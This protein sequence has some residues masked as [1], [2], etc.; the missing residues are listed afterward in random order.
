MG[1]T[2]DIFPGQTDHMIET[3][4]KE[5]EQALENARYW[6]V[7]ATTDDLT[8]LH[9]RRMLG[10]IPRHISQRRAPHTKDDIT[11]LFIDLDDFGK[12]NK[13]FGDDVGDQ[14]LR[15]L[16]QMIRKNIRETDIAIRKGGDE[17]V[18]FL[19][20]T[21][22]ELAT[23]AVVKRLELMLDGE[24]A[25]T[26]NDNIIPIRGSIGVFAYD[27]DLSPL[28]NLRHADALMR[29]AKKARKEERMNAPFI[30]SGD[31]SAY[32]SSIS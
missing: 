30:M 28:D 32:A 11:L 24:L 16:G 29:E 7:M 5:L 26:V 10:E 27:K 2:N 22:P 1:N 19:M 21:T 14:A 20:G 31:I 12:L 18:L 8:G 13:K 17:F 15:L 3:L 4:Q 25:L 9:N 23:G 6:E